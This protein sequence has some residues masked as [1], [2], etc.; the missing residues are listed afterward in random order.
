M[1]RPHVRMTN[2]QAEPSMAKVEIPTPIAPVF[3]IISLLASLLAISCPPI[4]RSLPTGIG[5]GGQAVFYSHLSMAIV[6]VVLLSITWSGS[7][8]VSLCRHERAILTLG[9]GLLGFFV[10]ATLCIVLWRG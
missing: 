7:A 4:F 10:A 9:L 8:I 6:A 2:S 1:R 3:A 5:E